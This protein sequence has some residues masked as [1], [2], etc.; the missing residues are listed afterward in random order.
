M[1]WNFR[2]DEKESFLLYSDLPELN[3]AGLFAVNWI[4]AMD[5]IGLKEAGK[6][7]V[8]L[9]SCFPG[10]SVEQNQYTKWLNMIKPKDVIQ[11]NRQT[12]N[13]TW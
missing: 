4:Y 6:G 13:S 5:S 12:G 11:G 2:K 9:F 3:T 7:G 1:S 8:A 10:K